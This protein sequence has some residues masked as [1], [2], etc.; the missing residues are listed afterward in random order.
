M[1]AWG[2][3]GR[4]HY[5]CRKMTGE[6]TG[7]TRVVYDGRIVRL[8]LLGGKW[9][10]VRHAD[11]V[12]I[13]A[14]NDVGE[15]LLVRQERRAVG[16]FTVEAPAGLI[17]PGETPEQA[18]RRE[19]QEE[20]GLDGDVTL[21]TRFYASPGFCDEF[22]HVF[23]ATNLRE[24]KLPHDEDEEGIEV[25]WLPPAQ[26]LAGLRDGSLV[27]S[28]STVAAAMHAVILLACRPGGA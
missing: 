7:E 25:L 12:A 15:M 4:V 24:R 8:E 5:S 21:I 22:L 28:A 26:V 10:V 17:D 19:L 23:E 9:E 3:W 14:L 27:G 6:T 18:A 20:A 11:A 13:L 2:G 1:T 16:A